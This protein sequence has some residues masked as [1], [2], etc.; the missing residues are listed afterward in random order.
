MRVGTAHGGMGQ[1]NWATIFTPGWDR[2]WEQIG[3]LYMALS[4]LADTL[5]FF[6]FKYD[7]NGGNI[8]NWVPDSAVNPFCIGTDCREVQ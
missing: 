5:D 7:Y 6:F 2:G 4:V 3:R 1:D 8:D